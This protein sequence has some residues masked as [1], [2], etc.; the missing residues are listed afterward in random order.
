MGSSMKPQN[1][2]T[3]PTQNSFWFL[4][5]KRT[6]LISHHNWMNSF[7]SRILNYMPLILHMMKSYRFKKRWMD[8]ARCCQPLNFGLNWTQGVKKKH[9][10]AFS[11]N[12]LFSVQYKDDIKQNM[13]FSVVLLH[14]RKDSNSFI[15]PDLDKIPPR[16]FKSLGLYIFSFCTVVVDRYFFLEKSWK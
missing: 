3:Q 6:R 11:T 12:F 2:C 14:G 7:W 10:W 15:L 8:P 13:V 9:C 16:P 4:K 5:R 1:C